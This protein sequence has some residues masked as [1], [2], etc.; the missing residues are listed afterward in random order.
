MVNFTKNVYP[1]ENL[2]TQSKKI[3]RFQI[4]FTNIFNCKNGIT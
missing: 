1:L 2:H 4:N 3:I